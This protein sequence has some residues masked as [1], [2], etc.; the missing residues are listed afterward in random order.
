MSSATVTSVCGWWPRR[1]TC[2]A[3]SVFELASPDT[4]CG[5]VLAFHRDALQG[6][7][8]ALYTL[9]GVRNE[10]TESEHTFF[11]ALS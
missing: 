6:G 8:P 5:G 7:G 9:V 4:A 2:E 10:S 3:V 1:Y 11:A